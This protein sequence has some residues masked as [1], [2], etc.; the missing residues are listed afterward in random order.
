[1]EQV[2]ASSLE[3]YSINP[4]SALNPFPA[5]RE[6]PMEQV[7]YCSNS[8]YFNPAGQFPSLSAKHRWSRVC[9]AR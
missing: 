8:E 4:G 9:I 6:A 7:E 5:E 2:D 1:M 3:L